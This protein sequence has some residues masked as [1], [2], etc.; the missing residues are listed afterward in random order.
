MALP[1]TTFESCGH[2]VRMSGLDDDEYVYGLIK[3]DRQFYEFD[4]LDFVRHLPLGA[5]AAIDVGA[6]LG[7]HTVFFALVMQ[8]RT[9]AFEVSA[10]NR[11]ALRA[12]VDA[13]GIGDLVS[14]HDYGLHSE[15]ALGSIVENPEN[16]GQT[17]VVSIGSE[18][19]SA[20]VLK[21]LDSVIS[22]DERIALIKVDVEGAELDVLRGSEAILDRD[23]PICLVEGHPGPRF[24]ELAQFFAEHGFRPVQI[25]GRSENWVFV[26]HDHLKF[27]QP[28]VDAYVVRT[29]NRMLA[30]NESRLRSIQSRADQN[31]QSAAALKADLDRVQGQIASQIAVHAQS[32]A[33][34][35]D[36]V[37]SALE[38]SAWAAGAL[39]DEVRAVRQA[40]T[41]STA[42]IRDLAK[43]V[44]DHSRRNE[45]RFDKIS[46]RLAP[47]RNRVMRRTKTGIKAAA[48]RLATNGATRRMIMIGVPRPIRRRAA[49]RLLG[50]K[51]EAQKALDK[52]PRVVTPQEDPPNPLG[53][54]PPYDLAAIC[55]AYPGGKRVYGGEFVKTRV[56]KY[57]EIGHRTLVIESS[58]DNDQPGLDRCDGTDVLRIS[59]R[60]LGFFLRF[61][62]P[63]V[64]A[65][66]AH[67]PSPE[68]LADLAE[69]VP[70]DRQVH[71]FHGYEVRDYRRLYFN[72]T[73][74]ELARLRSRLDVVNRERLRAAATC[75]GDPR[76][77]KV[78]VS[79]FLRGVAETDT[80]QKAANSHVIPNFVDGEFYRFAQKTSDQARRMLLIRSFASRNYANDI[81][82]E[83]IAL[84]SDRPGFDEIQFTIRGFGPE[85][86]SLTDRLSNL[87]NVDVEEGLLS[88]DAI[89][90]LHADHGVFICPTRFDTQG[91]SMGEAMASGLV[92]VTNDTA[93]IP[94]FTDPDCSVLVRADD[95]AAYAEALWA[96][97]EHPDRLPEMSRNATERVRAQCGSE[98]T[99]QRELVLIEQAKRVR[100]ATQS[101]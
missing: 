2:S 33:E 96:L 10:K 8:R 11:I 100:E 40:Q 36:D 16:M 92:V 23:T 94:E 69:V 95:P 5:G 48:R 98:Q 53:P 67:S 62:E 91:V 19:D 80:G 18:D 74:P 86:R 99:I 59:P 78:F 35:I 6:N 44:G 76:S 3:Q 41:A 52:P 66:L 37:K 1:E 39:G 82:I 13:N 32:G 90:E 93:A 42:Q 61:L 25:L 83:A 77:S 17:R 63:S 58:S 15:D 20:V 49:D 51:P 47:V 97:Y 29:Q 85:F 89:V 56:D 72:Y 101:V 34:G 45:V 30:N 73:T 87:R 22:E 43:Q 71:W 26:H 50:R 68:T 24:D 81:A 28:Y 64:N 54:T 57:G 70:Q 14:V 4:L 31:T 79:E 46:E 65:F 27:L 21:R 84:L 60:H 55:T 38:R 12:N 9:H 88:R 75:F 7:N